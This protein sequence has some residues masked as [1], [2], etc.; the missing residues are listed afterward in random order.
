VQNAGSH[1]VEYF[2]P[3]PIFT[4]LLLLDNINRASP[5]VLPS[6]LGVLNDGK[7]TVNGDTY[8]QI[9]PFMAC[10]TRSTQDDGEGTYQ[11]S[12]DQLDRF[13]LSAELKHLSVADVS[14]LLYADIGEDPSRL[15]IAFVENITALQAAVK[16]ICLTDK[17]IDKIAH[18]GAALR[19]SEV[20]REYV[21]SSLSLR[22]AIKLKQAV[23]ALSLVRGRWQASMD[24]LHHLLIP[25]LRHR[26]V[27]TFSARAQGIEVIDII[28]RV[29]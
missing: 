13:L 19:D 11:L 23:Q 22:G 28:K 10:A 5:R 25:A 9:S 4:N 18:I 3:G 8:S 26:I 16:S 1:T 7:V 15:P 14:E 27:L 24:D 6:L 12:A 21:A 20:G 17:I 2:Q 29:M